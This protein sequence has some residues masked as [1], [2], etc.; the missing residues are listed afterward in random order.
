MNGEMTNLPVCSTVPDGPVV[1][2]RLLD[3]QRDAPES[4]RFVALPRNLELGQQRKFA[5]HPNVAR[6]PQIMFLRVNKMSFYGYLAKRRISNRKRLGSWIR[7]AHAVADI[8]AVG[9]K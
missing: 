5:S 8:V 3:R 9:L 4:C 1:G 2:E 7:S 6:L